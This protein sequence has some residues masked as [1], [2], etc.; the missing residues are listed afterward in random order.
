MTTQEAVALHDLAVVLN[1]LT[2]VLNGLAVV[3]ND[4]TVLFH[5]VS[6]YFTVGPALRNELGP[7]RGPF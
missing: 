2:V 4:L 5:G 7:T 3:F 6:R 1:G